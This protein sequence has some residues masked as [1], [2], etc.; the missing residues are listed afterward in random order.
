MKKQ[1]LIIACICYMAAAC[2]NNEVNKTEESPANL[3][4]S[5]EDS[6]IQS[7]NDA[8]NK[9]DTIALAKMF[10]EK[11]VMMS[12]SQTITGADSIMKKWINDQVHIVANLKTEKVNGATS[13][14]MAY[15]NGFWK[16]DLTNDKDSITGQS[17]GN[18]TSVWEKEKDG[19][20][21]MVLIHM[22]DSK[23]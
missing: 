22:G 3:S 11:S 4:A 23:N 8:W 13:E 16:L 15:Y 19:N 5:V 18:F 7:W 6:L 1:F 21:K 2:N 10:N 14:G 9:N 17:E 20:W 12:G